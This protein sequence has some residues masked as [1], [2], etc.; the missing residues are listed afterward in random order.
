MCASLVPTGAPWGR[1]VA[2]A[3]EPS[4]TVLWLAPAAGLIN[5]KPFLA[6]AVAD[7]A[8]GKAA[9]ALPVFAG[10][11]ADPAVGGYAWLYVGRA[12]LALGRQDEAAAAARQLTLREPAGYLADAA[13]SLAADVADAAGDSAA[14]LRA[15]QALAQGQPLAPEQAWLR[16]GRAAERAGNRDLATQALSRVYYDF[17]LTPEAEDAAAG[18]ARLAPATGRPSAERYALDLTRAQ[19]FYAARRYADA[20][21]AFEALRGAATGDDRVFLQLRVAECDFSL[22]RYAA[23]RDALKGILEKPTP[24]ESEA[25]FFYVSTLRGLGRGADYVARARAFANR[26]DAGTFAEEALNDLAT[27]YVLGDDDAKAA[28]VFGEMFRRFPA[29]PHADRAAW[30][31]GWWA[32]KSGRFSETI[33]IF[34]SAATASRR[35]DYRPSWLYW[36]ARAHAQIG[37]REAAADGFRRVIGDYRNSYY[38]RQADR[39][40]DTLRGGA[41]DAG[42][43]A[44]TQGRLDLPPTIVTGTPP[45]NADLIRSLLQAGLYDD[46]VSE[47]RK[48]QTVSGSSSLIEATIA[49]AL[50]RKGD[51]RPAITAM[52]RAYPQ[53]MAEGGEALPADLRAIIFPVDYWDLIYKYATARHLDPYLMAALVA[54]E[55]TF[56]AGVR[57]SANAW[58]LMQVVPATGKRYAQMLGLR[59]F[60][61]ARLT[62][63]ETNLRIGM[64]YFADLL[65]RFGDVVPALAAYNAGEQR[66]SRWLTERPGFGRD[67]FTDDIPFPE[68]QNYVKRV[69]GTAD[70]YRAL[71]GKPNS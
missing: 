36:A 9:R 45:P 71:Y 70:D 65:E 39:A 48:V 22:K 6:G 35:A 46:A 37:E 13:L 20:R 50:N 4:G 33:R 41:P 8:D 42:S 27:Y 66:V 60:T 18:L 23:A 29:G 54:Q 12:Q 25:T 24:L 26:A 61:T 2:S 40:L 49:Y 11:T 56:D 64:A 58:G 30:R 57:S 10:A 68:T 17:A 51:L 32:Y 19:Q 28:E 21:K 55:S 44:A 69:V 7:L 5:T 43:A 14:A 38:G 59:P 16:L 47:L 67:E 15:L 63:P 53:F 52:R 1:P 3:S 62:E 31:S 34:E